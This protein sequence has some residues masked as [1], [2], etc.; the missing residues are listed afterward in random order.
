MVNFFIERKS[1]KVFR[2]IEEGI[3]FNEELIGL[4]ANILYRH[5]IADGKE[6]RE[7]RAYVFIVVQKIAKIAFQL[8]RKAPHL[9]EEIL[10]AIMDEVLVDLRKIIQ[11]QHRSLEASDVVQ[12][13]AEVEFFAR[14]LERKGE[15]VDNSIHNLKKIWSKK[16][17][18]KKLASEKDVMGGD[19]QG[20]KENLINNEL[21]KVKLIQSSLR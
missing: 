7:L 1:G 2:V 3:T 6:L 21:N 16:K 17:G 12:I 8:T 13:W 19:L 5:L 18:L 15:E 11:K 20:V 10:D 14:F 4:D 9:K